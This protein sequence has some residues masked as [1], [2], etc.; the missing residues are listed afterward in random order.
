MEPFLKNGSSRLFCVYFDVT[1][2]H[3]RGLPFH[4]ST[5]AKLEVHFFSMEKL[6]QNS[7]SGVADGEFMKNVH[8]LSG[9]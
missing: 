2:A 1:N 8:V 4:A 3:K 7:E 6:V 9:D 5:L